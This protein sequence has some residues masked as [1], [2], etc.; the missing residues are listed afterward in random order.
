MGGRLGRP[1][2]EVHEAALS[3][4]AA[5]PDPFFVPYLLEAITASP[6]SA[7]LAD[8]LE[9]HAADLAP[10]AVDRLAREPVGPSRERLTWALGVMRDSLP[11]APG[12]LARSSRPRWPPTRPGSPGRG[13]PRLRSA[14]DP[15]LE[16]LRRAL[17]ED[18]EHSAD[19]LA[20]HLAMH[21]GRRRVDRIVAALAEPDRS[22]G[23]WRSSCWRC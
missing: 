11:A 21:Y 23:P 12:G 10:V 15:A 14:D 4:C 5:A 9:R 20:E 18:V 2:S 3:G 17:V 7:A 8:A 6:P 16:T 22:S 19:M 1:R 13:P